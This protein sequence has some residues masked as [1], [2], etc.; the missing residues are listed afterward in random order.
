MA[1]QSV[2]HGSVFDNL[3]VQGIIEPTH[4]WPFPDVHLPEEYSL[5]TFSGALQHLHNTNATVLAD[6]IVALNCRSNCNRPWNTQQN[7]PLHV[8]NQTRVLPGESASTFFARL[9]QEENEFLSSV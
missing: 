3:T 4:K 1:S 7:T 6:T 2:E 8:Q 9:F 5:V